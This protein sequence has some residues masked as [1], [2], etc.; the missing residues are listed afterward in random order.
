MRRLNW[1]DIAGQITELH[2]IGAR[3]QRPAASVDKP[4][5]DIAVPCRAI[6]TCQATLH[7][8]DILVKTL[9]TK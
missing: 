1:L 7:P 6:K 4:S 5:A 8:P 3:G 9:P 2:G